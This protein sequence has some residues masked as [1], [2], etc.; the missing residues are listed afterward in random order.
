MLLLADVQHASKAYLALKLSR[1]LP[2]KA[3]ASFP[4]QAAD[5][6]GIGLSIR[7]PIMAGLA[8]RQG[9]KYAQDFDQD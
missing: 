4:W 7:T 2:Q 9:L 8:R 5:I 3:A 6:T 1:K